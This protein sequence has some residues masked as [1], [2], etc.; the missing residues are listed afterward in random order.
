MV[1]EDHQGLLLGARVA[2]DGQWRFPVSDSLPVKYKLAL[3]Q[4]E[5]RRFG[6]HPGIDPLGVVRAVVQN[7]R[8]RRVVSGA[9]TLHMQVMRLSA[10]ARTRSWWHKI[11]EAVQA[12]RLAFG[13]SSDHVLRLYAAHAPFGG[14]VV[15]L[16]AATWRYFGKPPVAINWAE[17]ATL[18]VL[19]NSPA[20][21]HPGRNRGLL[22]EKRNR[23]LKRLADT[24]IIDRTTA[25][26]SSGEPLPDTP[27]P[28]PQWTPQLVGT[29][30]PGRHTLHIESALQQQ[31]FEVVNRHL[32]TLDGQGIHNACVLIAEVETGRVLAYVANRPDNNADYEGAVDI[33]RAPRSTGS[34]L[35]PFLFAM[36]TQ[37]GEWLP[38]ALVE[39]LPVR[40][41]SFKPEN[42][43]K[44]YD[45]AVRAR[46][47][48]S[49]S[50]NVPFSHLLNTYGVVRF[51]H[52]LK[53]IG[54]S[55]I[56]KPASH[57]GLSLILG[58]A[59][60]SL[61]DITAAYA[62]MARV[63]AHYYPYQG[64]YDKNDWHPLW[65]HAHSNRKSGAAL[66]RQKHGPV[67]DAAAAWCT[68]DAMSE[69]E[70]PDAEGNWDYF[71]TSRRVAWKTGTSM[72]FRDAWAIGVTPQYVVGVWV[73][74]AD[75]EGR[76]GLIGVE[77]AAPLLFDLFQLLPSNLGW[78]EQPYD[79]MEPLAVCTHSGFR[80][81]PYCMVD[82]AWVP[83]TGNK[84]ATCVYCR[85]LHVDV[86]RQYQ[87][88]LS[89]AQTEEISSVPWFVLPSGVEYYYRLKNPAYVPPPPLRHD[90][91]DASDSQAGTLQIIYPRNNA[92]LVVPNELD[93]SKGYVVFRSAYR[94]PNTVLKWYLDDKLLGSTTDFHTIQAQPL[95]GS[96][97]LTVVDPA[98]LREVVLF[99]V[100]E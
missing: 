27:L 93:G 52:D 94:M 16:E 61:W 18:A 81:G 10:G 32:A 63:A 11:V 30:P 40:F 37:H 23:L 1:V 44:T 13:Y 74:N 76:A 88:N 65:L 35:K 45:G 7:I 82:T 71:E 29:L 47:A 12:T 15:G 96:H 33:I 54:L 90:C 100:S 20:L 75:G 80:A 14:N 62:N 50:L 21:I 9:S 51:H 64:R 22:L 86:A 4:F 57:Y 41:G 91:G 72:G 66:M 69:L 25:E 42:Y 59:E 24:G 46:R 70:R 48:L 58:G 17:A 99:E 2:A 31:A 43:H 26:L 68:L 8:G 56:S 73:G 83:L 38:Q 79:N 84:S 87:L 85:L 49:R 19:P 97:R 36:M 67:M 5:D 6:W 53:K 98:G 34:L 95:P 77:V 3:L 92:R 55:H 89:C 78:F 28:L 39:D 60:S